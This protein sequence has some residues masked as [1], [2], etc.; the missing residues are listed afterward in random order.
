MMEAAHLTWPVTFVVKVFL[1]VCRKGTVNQT[2][3]ILFYEKS[4]Y[5]TTNLNFVRKKHT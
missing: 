4:F 1:R 2:L 3:R 5:L